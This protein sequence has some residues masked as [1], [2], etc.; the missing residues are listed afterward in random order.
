MEPHWRAGV[1]SVS[2][3]AADYGVSRA[4]IHKHWEKLGIG[5]DLSGKIRAEADAIVARAE[6]KAERLQRMVTAPDPVTDAETVSTN[7]AIQA[8]AILAERTDVRRFRSLANSLL[9]ELEATTVDRALF[10]Q[11]GDMMAKPD[12]KGVDKLNDLYVKVTSMMGRVDSTKK[13]AET[14]KILIGLERQV[15]NIADAVPEDGSKGV[16]AAITDGI[17]TLRDAMQKRLAQ[18]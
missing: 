11:L 15:L 10:A 1:L 5:R 14:L 2:K 18:A 16:A 3:L 17:S 9:D 8:A 12:D 6:V 13:L 4:A 7:A